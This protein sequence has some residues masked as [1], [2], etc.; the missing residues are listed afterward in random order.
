MLDFILENK[1]HITLISEFV[2]ALCGSFHL[3]KTQKT[4]RDIKYFVWFLW[5]VFFL[6]FSGLYALWAFFDNYKTFPFLEDSLFQR[7]VWLHNWLIL[8]SLSFYN[9]LF[10]KQLGR[11]AYKRILN[12]A[13][14][15][16]ILFGIFKLISSNQLFYSYDMTV[17]IAGVLLLI[18]T[19]ASYYF[20][21]LMSD[22]VLQFKKSLLFYISAGLLVWHLCVPPIQIYSAYFSVENIE[23]I[24]LYTSVLM[25]CNIFLYGIFSFAFIYC[26]Q[27]KELP[28]LKKKGEF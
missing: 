19:I 22:Q 18:I 9:F 3:F 1:I 23:F 13:L 5:F 7:N 14:L 17:L 21:L 6:D 20:G 4:L 11:V 2:A 25:Y 24:K 16:F 26:A 8:I 10:I 12:F 27:E 28:I 15:L